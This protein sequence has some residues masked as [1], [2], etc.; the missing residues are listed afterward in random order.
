MVMDEDTDQGCV[1]KIDRIEI[2]CGR[3]PGVGVV[4]LALSPVGAFVQ[5]NAVDAS[6]HATRSIVASHERVCWQPAQV[7]GI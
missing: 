5:R 2:E 4:V 3:K 6:L 7:A 1:E